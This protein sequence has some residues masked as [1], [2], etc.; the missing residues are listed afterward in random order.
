M[1]MRPAGGSPALNG[2]S[3]PG[4]NVEIAKFSKNYNEHGLCY[5]CRDN[6]FDGERRMQLFTESTL[7]ATIPEEVL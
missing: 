1:P 3:L 5:S 6:F 4:K 2:Q 7:S